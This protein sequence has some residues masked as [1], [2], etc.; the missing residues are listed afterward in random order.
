MLDQRKRHVVQH[1]QRIEQRTHL[2]QKPK[3]LS[4][5]HQLLFGQIVDPLAFE[6]DL[7]GVGLKQAHDVLE[8]NALSRAAGAD[9]DNALARLDAERDIVENNE[10]AEAFGDVA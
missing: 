6:P 10:P 4:H 2:K 7:A 3:V 1:I 9:D 8:Q 5:L